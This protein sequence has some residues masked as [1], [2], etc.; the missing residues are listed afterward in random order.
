MA[1]RTGIE[2]FADK[3][4]LAL[5]RA[6]LSRTALAQRVGVDK[7]VVARWSS[8]ALQ[9]AD[10]S[11]AALSAALGQAIPGFDRTAW[12]LPV[13]AFA[14]RLGVPLPAGAAPA[15]DE[16]AIDFALEVTADSLPQAV[17]SYAGIWVMLYPSMGRP[18]ELHGYAG[19]MHLPP[20]QPALF[21]NFTS[22]G[23]VDARGHAFAMQARL[24]CVFR[25]ARLRN[26]VGLQL[27][28]GVHDDTAE[29]LDGI[30]LSQFAGVDRILGA[31]RVIW[32]RL[33]DGTA[34]DAYA[35]A[36]ARTSAL[37]GEWNRL[38]TPALAAF[39]PEA[40]EGA[41]AL[42][43]LRVTPAESWT[44]GRRGVVPGAG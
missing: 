8:G 13:P 17:A 30:M 37:S 19:R 3:L 9:P 26:M 2:A 1:R 35:A 28:N 18:G 34:D 39:A 41:V 6:N 32:F 36:I 31:G 20:G 23:T 11:L 5:G 43:Q 15:L 7:S 22:G 33:T 14:A 16:S 10:H 38:V 40:P 42:R 27:L 29:I 12:D 24:S 21:F 4:R 44:T 25:S